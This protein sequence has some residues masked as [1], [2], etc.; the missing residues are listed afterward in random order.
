MSRMIRLICVGA[1]IGIVMPRVAFADIYGF[2]D[3]AGV[4]HFAPE[5]VDARYQLFFREGQHASDIVPRGASAADGEL[6]QTRL[7]HRVVD[8]PNVR[9]FEPLI[10]RVAR[11]EGADPALVKSVIATESA[12]DPNAVSSKGAV[13]LMQVLPET[14]MRYGLAADR[15][16]SVAQKLSE[17]LVNLRIGTRYLQDLRA[18]F[19]DLPLALAAYNS[20]ENNV[21]RFNNQIPPFPETVAYVKVVQQFFSFYEPMRSPYISAGRLH[22]I[23]PARRNL[24][25]SLAGGDAPAL[26]IP[27]QPV[28][29]SSVLHIP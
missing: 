13:G 27:D 25:A 12:F 28:E 9:K 15:K 11:E 2:V 16:R 14:A 29:P 19:K 18:M 4:T 1:L 5:P 3:E 8:E 17:P 22:V 21:K 23:L 6:M 10:V 20:G 24:P 7:F 26:V